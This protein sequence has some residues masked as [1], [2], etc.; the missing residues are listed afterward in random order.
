M[1]DLW[2]VFCMVVILMVLYMFRGVMFVAI[3]FTFEVITVIAMA[4][5]FATDS[6]NRWLKKLIT[7]KQI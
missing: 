4:I 2:T 7:G 3:I 6:F 1:V 5:A